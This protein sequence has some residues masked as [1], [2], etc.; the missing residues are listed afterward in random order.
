MG[1][2]NC[3]RT[4]RATS[5]AI[6]SN[7]TINT[8]FS[9]N[10]LDNGMRFILTLPVDLPAM[11]TILPVRIS[12]KVNGVTTLIPVQD[13]IGNNLMSDQLRFFPRIRDCRCRNKGIVRIVFGSNPSHFKVLQCL[14]ESS[15]VEFEEEI[16]T[17]VA[18]TSKTTNSN[19]VENK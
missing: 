16:D 9:I 1:C 4:I 8:D 12:I 2:N 13:I 18:S 14:P 6:G 10:D 19:K 11:V 3:N 17:I 5:Y 15:A 7:F